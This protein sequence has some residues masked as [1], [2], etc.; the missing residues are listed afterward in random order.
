M[1][2]VSLDDENTVPQAL[3]TAQKGWHDAK[4]RPE[5]QQRIGHSQ[6]A[7]APK[8]SKLGIDN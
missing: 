1:N 2:S 3:A 5:G 8:L 4:N 7:N 6:A